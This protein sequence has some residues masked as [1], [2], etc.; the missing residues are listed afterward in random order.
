MNDCTNCKLAQDF[1]EIKKEVALICGRI[2]EVEKTS[3]VSDE[4]IKMIFNILKEIKDSIKDI[5]TTISNLTSEKPQKTSQ[6][7]QLLW[8][9]AGTVLGALI[10]AGLKFI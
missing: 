10:I 8:G 4:Q 1:I 5:A 3:A 9:I 6:S 7:T 2:S